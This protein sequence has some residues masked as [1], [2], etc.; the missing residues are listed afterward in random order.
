VVEDNDSIELARYVRDIPAS[1]AEVSTDELGLM[2]ERVAKIGQV[3]QGRI[4]LEAKGRLQ[5]GEWQ[6]WLKQYWPLSESQARRYMQLA[7]GETKALN[8][9]ATPAK[10]QPA[11]K[12]RVPTRTSQPAGANRQSL[13]VAQVQEMVDSVPEDAL[14]VEGEVQEQQ[15]LSGWALVEYFHA[16]VVDKNPRALAQL[17][18]REGHPEVVQQLAEFFREAAQ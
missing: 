9:R 6:A 5:H 4:L 15:P 11:G 7:T 10:P 1:L 16:Y 3:V 2:L 14:P 8:A 13:P 18:R 12:T 17:A